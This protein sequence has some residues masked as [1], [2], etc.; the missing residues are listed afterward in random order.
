MTKSEV[1]DSDNVSYILDDMHAYFERRPLLEFE[2]VMEEMRKSD[3]VGALRQVS[4]DLLIEQGLSMAQCSYS[5]DNLDRWAEVSSIRRWRHVT[6]WQITGR[7][8]PSIVLEVLQVLEAE[9]DLREETRVTE[10][11]EPGLS[12]RNT[13]NG[14]RACQ[15][16]RI[17][18][19]RE[20]TW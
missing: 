9:V 15:K 10:Q 17:D 13:D 4:G 19:S 5:S 2:Q 20:L 12:P 18:C 14:T 16:V 3:V 7:F 8:A 11:A 1:Q 6:R